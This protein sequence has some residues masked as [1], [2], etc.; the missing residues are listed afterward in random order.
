MQNVVTQQL[1]V[2]IDSLSADRF[3]CVHVCMWVLRMLK[4]LCRP[5]NQVTRPD[6]K[7]KKRKP[8][9]VWY[10]YFDNKFNR[11]DFVIETTLEFL[12]RKIQ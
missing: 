11:F 8:V 3:F 5:T 9:T 4:M 7:F 2:T 10:M 6:Y 1:L 12:S